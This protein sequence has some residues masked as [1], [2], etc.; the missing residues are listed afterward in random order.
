MT[1]AAINSEFTKAHKEH[2]ELEEKNK[3]KKL[4]VDYDNETESIENETGQMTIYQLIT[5]RIYAK[6]M[7]QFLRK[8]QAIKQITKKEDRKLRQKE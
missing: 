7:I 6:K 2:Q 5:G 4:K 8:R 1:L 3:K